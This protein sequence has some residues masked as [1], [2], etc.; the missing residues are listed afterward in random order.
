MKLAIATLLLLTV[1]LA[2]VPAAPA[3]A[4]PIWPGV[5]ELSDLPYSL[6]IPSN[7]SS[8]HG[9]TMQGGVGGFEP[10]VVQ[11]LYS[12]NGD[13]IVSVGD[14]IHGPEAVWRERV[15]VVGVWR[16]YRMRESGWI[17]RVPTGFGGTP[18]GE[19]WSIV[20]PSERWGEPYQVQ[21]FIQAIPDPGQ[22]P[23]A[24]DQVLIDGAWATID[25]A[26][27][28]VDGDFSVPVRRTTW[29]RIKAL[30]GASD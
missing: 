30:L 15:A 21:G 5:F 9:L 26:R 20:L 18:V 8:W 7:G 25:A 17:V 27:L 16:L 24:E 22:L 11:T 13:G 1:V 10:V 28:C 6:S 4:N 3:L 19:T 23:L 29:G 12:D 14:A 2:L